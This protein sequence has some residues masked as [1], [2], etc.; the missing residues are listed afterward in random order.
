MSRPRYQ[1]GSL[2]IMPRKN[3]P[4]VWVYRWRE[5]NGNGRRCLR[6]QV[7]GTVQQYAT[8]VSAAR[9]VE[10]LKLTVNQQDF[11]RK[12]VPR[13]FAALVEHYRSKELPKDNHV[14]KT[15][16]TKQVY[17]YTLQNYLVPR[18]GDYRLR[19]FSS[20][21]IEEWLDVL[22]LAPSTRAKIR[23]VMSSIFRHG[24]RW[25]WIGQNENPVTLVRVSSKRLRTPDILDAAEFQALFAKLPD[26]ERAM[27]T[28][29][30]TTGLRVSEALG[31]KWEDIDFVK[32][33]ANVVRSVVDGSVGRCKTEVSQQPVPLDRLTL[34]HLQSWRS[35]TSYA[36][37]SDWVFASDRKFG[38]M[39]V[40]A[41]ASL[42][43]VLK[44]AARRAGVAK[45]IGWHTFR[46][47]Y[48][49][50]LAESG[51]DVRVVQELMR[52]AKVSTTMELYTHARMPKK[53]E[54]Q[55]RVVD[56]LFS[57]QR[58]GAVQ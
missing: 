15:R 4:A 33:L 34:E 13:T 56:M 21:E 29:C 53:R 49:S 37:G 8:K 1:N 25:G 16:K 10:S 57:R 24:I 58:E 48:S 51:D 55:S 30:A 28:I 35:K 5:T 22:Q 47:T 11:Q 7:V 31:L 17:E 39:P 45:T 19:E 42:S 6:K 38:K 2:K 43:K 50:L 46:H 3:G 14:K 18:W 36:L 52:H 20:V 9:Q 44:P 23:N 41:N 32:G 12:A 26:R 54:A 40:W 27:G